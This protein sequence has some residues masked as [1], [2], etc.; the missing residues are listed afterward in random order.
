MGIFGYQDYK[1]FLL[2]RIHN[3][4]KKGRGEM[5][6]MA[7]FLNVH[8]T[9]IS[10]ILRGPRDLSPEQALEFSQY[11][12]LTRSE[13]EYFLTLVEIERAGSLRLKSFLEL[14]RNRLQEKTANRSP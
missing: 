14:R 10:Q 4:P 5:Q 11:F 13:T 9:L 6:R 2:E 8:P 12:G 3:L 1:S 7:Y